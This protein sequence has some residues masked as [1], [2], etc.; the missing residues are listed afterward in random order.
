MGKVFHRTPVPHASKRGGDMQKQGRLVIGNGE[1]DYVDRNMDKKGSSEEQF[2][3]T[4]IIQY[5]E[6]F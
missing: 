2:S 3:K 6:K 1:V 4:S 5:S